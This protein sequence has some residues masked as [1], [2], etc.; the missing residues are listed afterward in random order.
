MNKYIDTMEGLRGMKH[1][2]AIA[3]IKTA[4]AQAGITPEQQEED[5]QPLGWN[6]CHRVAQAAHKAGAEG[7]KEIMSRPIDMV[8][9]CPSCGMQ[10]ID[11]PDQVDGAAEVKTEAVFDTDG[12]HAGY[13]FDPSQKWTNPPHRSHLCS[14]CGHVWRPAD[15]P[16]NGVV[17]V[18]TK[19]KKDSPV[20][21]DLLQALTAVGR[22]MVELTTTVQG[23]D[24]WSMIPA[25]WERCMEQRDAFLSQ[26]LATNDEPLTEASGYALEVVDQVCPELAS[27]EDNSVLLSAKQLET[28]LRHFGWTPPC[29]KRTRLST[30]TPLVAEATDLMDDA[31]SKHDLYTN[32]DKD[33]PKQICDSNGDVVLGQCKRCGKAEVELNEPCALLVDETLGRSPSSP[34]KYRG[35]RLSSEELY[36][37]QR[38]YGQYRRFAAGVEYR[39]FTN[40]ELKDCLRNVEKVLLWKNGFPT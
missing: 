2:D 25:I 14:G 17:A 19:G 9:H 18:T 15:V 29:E 3:L 22:K 26:L 1:D 39:I 32:A 16:T 28:L 10:H 31:C 11:A 36:V 6:I 4:M 24:E 37:T 40:D 5:V 8:L 35:L 34:Q 12:R 27:R 7:M 13:L 38:H 30:D 20:D 21:P 23:R 33:R